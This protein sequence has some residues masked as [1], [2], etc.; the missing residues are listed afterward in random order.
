MSGEDLQALIANRLM[1]I[2]RGNPSM[3]GPHPG[4]WRNADAL[5]EGELRETL[6]LA[7][8]GA[9]LSACVVASLDADGPIVIAPDE[10][11]FL[12]ASELYDHALAAGVP[13]EP[14][15]GDAG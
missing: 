2:R 5:I 11:E 6:R 15:Q 7:R 8:I 4:D 12:Y 10:T 14:P 13:V 9:A 3:S 1:M